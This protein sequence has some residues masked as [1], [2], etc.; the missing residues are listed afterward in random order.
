MY[1]CLQRRVYHQRVGMLAGFL[2]D[3]VRQGKRK[4]KLIH[5]H[6]RPVCAPAPREVDSGQC[7]DC[8][9]VRIH[10]EHHVA[11]QGRHSRGR[12]SHRSAESKDLRDCTGRNA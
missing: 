12:L 3:I 4:R 5:D 6:S 1:Q 8:V 11:G 9:I 2:G 7:L 10:H